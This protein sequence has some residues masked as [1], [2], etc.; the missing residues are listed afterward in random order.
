MKRAVCTIL[1]IFL[2]VISAACGNVPEPPATPDSAAAEP[3]SVPPNE[4][5]AAA[6]SRQDILALF[7]PNAEPDWTIVDAVPAAD[8]AYDRVGVI[9][10]VDNDT[11]YTGLAFMNADGHFA[12]CGTA[13]YCSSARKTGSTPR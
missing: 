8:F 6:W 11:G 3:G 13:A 9:L 1:M 12:R 7:E 4:D 5:A 10:F 2:A